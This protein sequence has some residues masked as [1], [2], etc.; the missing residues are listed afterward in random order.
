MYTNDAYN[1]PN[2]E[3]IEVKV[4]QGFEGSIGEPI[5]GPVDNI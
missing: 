1:A 3:I 5:D 2:I 4:E